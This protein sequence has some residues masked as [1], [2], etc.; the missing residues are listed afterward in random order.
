MID[1]IQ[2]MLKDISSDMD[3]EAATGAGNHVS[4]INLDAK[5]LEETTSMMFHHNIAKL[6]FLYKRSRPNSQTS[7]AFLCTRVKAPDADDY[8]KLA[9]TMKYLQGMFNMPLTMLDANNMHDVK[10]WADASFA[11]H[12]DKKIHMGCVIADKGVIYGTSTHQKLNTKS[13]MEGKLVGAGERCHATGWSNTFGGTYC[14]AGNVHVWVGCM[15]A[16]LS[17]AVVEQSDLMC[18]VGILVS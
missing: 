7:V 13:S 2:N 18:L 11:V 3:G 9:R 8:K 10:W 5:P 15:P 6:L 17:I 12:S 4:Q 14:K 16:L 1:Y